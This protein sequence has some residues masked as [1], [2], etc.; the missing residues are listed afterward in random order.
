MNNETVHWEDTTSLNIYASNTSTPNFINL[1]LLDQK[2]RLSSAESMVNA[3]QSP[4]W[5]I[6]SAHRPNRQTKIETSEPNNTIDQ[7][8]LTGIYKTSTQTLQNHVVLSSPW[9]FLKKPLHY[10]TESKY[11]QIEMISCILFDHNEI[12]LVINKGNYRIY[13]N[14]GGLN[15]AQP[16]AERW[17]GHWRNQEGN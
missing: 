11:L 1:M 4:L 10:R 3:C 15:D 6:Y 5:W 16:A 13:T 12:K 17:M 7:T 8:F 14:S 2:Q 9:K